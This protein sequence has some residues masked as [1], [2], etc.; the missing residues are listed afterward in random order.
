M[1]RATY[2]SLDVAGGRCSRRRRTLAHLARVNQIV[3][4]DP[5]GFGEQ[6]GSLVVGAEWIHIQVCGDAAHGDGMTEEPT[7][8]LFEDGATPLGNVP[9]EALALGEAQRDDCP[10]DRG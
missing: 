4:K 1:A 9:E 3:G 8:P 5:A 2:L 10:F 7:D 6:S